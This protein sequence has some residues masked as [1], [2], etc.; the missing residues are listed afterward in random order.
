ML[1]RAASTRKSIAAAFAF[2]C[3]AAAP[4]LAQD[5]SPGDG[6]PTVAVMNFTNGALVRPADYAGLSQGIS[7]IL[8]VG[9]AAN[10]K[11][12]VVERQKIQAVLAE[13]KF[14]AT[15]AVDQETAVRLGRILGAQH[16]IMGSFLVDTKERVRIDV[17]SVNV[18]TGKI[19]Y[20]E[21][22]EGRSRE[23]LDVVD[24]LGE[25]MDKTLHLPAMAQVIPQ[26]RDGR[27]KA[28]QGKA[29]LLLGRAIAA[30]EKGDI[31]GARAAATEALVVFPEF[32]PAQTF[33]AS[34]PAA[35]P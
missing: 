6:L 20:V 27:A 34:L 18:E 33:V 2:G 10:A 30:K 31:S 8:V 23:L 32:Q 35:T 12:R 7:E 4:V 3:F 21:T 22:V 29:V 28:D 16:L 17:H 14:D 25:K 5:A 9:L 15:D 19:E 13:Q 1:S 11:V 24:R 26:S